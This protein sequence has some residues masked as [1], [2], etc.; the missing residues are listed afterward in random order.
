MIACLLCERQ[1]K[2]VEVLRKHQAKSELHRVSILKDADHQ[3][4]MDDLKE[5]K[6]AEL[7]ETL[8]LAQKQDTYRNR[9]LERRILDTTA[10]MKKPIKKTLSFKI[11]PASTYRRRVLPTVSTN[12]PIPEDNVGNKLLQK[13]GW[14]AGEGLGAKK[15]GIVAPIEAL[16]YS[17]GA[18]LGSLN[19]RR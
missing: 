13:M 3:S 7:K 1:F 9:A 2:S 17:S 11:K 8:T 6:V 18:G 12:T 10:G 5:K 15:D 16:A 19:T 4:N 14:K